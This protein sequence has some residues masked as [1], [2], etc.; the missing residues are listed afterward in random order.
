MS[1]VRQSG[2]LQKEASVK[3]IAGLLVLFLLVGCGG[4]GGGGGGGGNTP[5]GSGGTPI[6]SVSAT[7][8]ITQSG[9]VLN[10]NV[11][12]N[13]LDTQAW[14]EYGTDPGLL[15]YS[16]TPEQEIGQGLNAVPVNQSLSGCA[17]GTTYY[18]RVCGRNAKGSTKSTITGFTTSS[19]GAAPAVTTLA[20]TSVG[21]TTATLN[22][23]VTPN[24]LATNAWFE[25]GTDPSLTSPGS[26]STQ[27]VGSGTTSQPVNAALTGLSTGTTYY[28]R[29][30]ASNGSGTTKGSIA[31]FTPGAAPAV[32]TLAATSVGAT[33]ATL[34]GSVTPNGLATNAWFEYGTDPSL[35]SPGSTS[36]QAVGAGTASQTVNAGVTGLST[37]T[38]YYYRFAAGNGSG[39]TKGNIASFTPGA[40]PAVT[41]LAA[42]SV[43]AT[44]ATLNG[45]VTPNG[46]ATNA[47][48]EYG[49]DPSLASP[50]STSTQA[51]GAGTTGQPVNAGVTGLSTGTT[52][53]Y[54]VAA[55]NGSGTTRGSIASF[56][57]AAIATRDVVLSWAPNRESG[58]NSTGGG[59]QV[60]I[61]GQPA[62]NVPYTSGPTAPTSTTVSL[63]AGTYTVTVKAYAAL[64]AQGDSGGSLS[65]A[66]APITVNV[67]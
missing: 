30:A 21:A 67:P 1:F 59:Y 43:G 17:G 52:H 28:Y 6:A 35:A 60:L 22:G 2:I 19:P 16:G 12:P 20:A 15:T 14:F 49:T 4:G 61:S 62:I 54:R 24:G 3:R 45:S 26:T 46:L 27:A 7:T 10:G 9:A 25:Y 18:Y 47:W 57:P 55:S 56:T 39:T 64:D 5:Q 38:T 29:F 51:V 32:T 37:G 13:G 53:Y 48:F 63:Q 36:T 34:N 44:T 65:A 58:V 42:T 11:T 41:T 66:S 50:G 23:S 31:S 40:V 33:T 8:S